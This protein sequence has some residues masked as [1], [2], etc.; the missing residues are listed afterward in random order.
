MEL[1]CTLADGDLAVDHWIFRGTHTGELDGVPPTGRRVEFGGFDLA[2][3]RNGRIAEI[4]H[5]E[6]MAAM[7]ADLGLPAGPR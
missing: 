7:W 1:L 5:V 3:I 2:R 4:W 6:D